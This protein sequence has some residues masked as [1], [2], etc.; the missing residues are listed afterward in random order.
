MKNIP[1]NEEQ[2][3]DELRFEAGIRIPKNKEAKKPVQKS[4]EKKP[5]QKIEQSIEKPSEDM[6][7]IEPKRIVDKIKIKTAF[8]SYSEEL[9]K[10]YARDAADRKI[11]QSYKETK[12]VGFWNKIGNGLKRVWTHGIFREY[13]R[14]KE[15]SKSQKDILE[16]RN[17]FVDE[18]LTNN[19]QNNLNAALIERL[20]S[21]DDLS[22]IAHKGEKVKKLEDQNIKSR[23]IDIIRRYTFDNMTDNEF[24]YYQ[25]QLINEIKQTN[26]DIFEDSF[27]D[28]NNLLETAKGLK[29]TYSHQQGL[30]NVDI[31]LDIILGNMKSGLRTEQKLNTVERLT[32]KLSKTKLGKFINETTL[33]S[34]LSIFQG[35]GNTV[36]TF[37]LYNKVAQIA[38]FGGTALLSGIL[39]SIRNRTYW[40]QKRSQHQREVAG[41]R[42][43]TID[44]KD[45]QRKALE[46]FRF[47]SINAATT[48]QEFDNIL[49]FIQDKE[50]VNKITYEDMSKYISE[51]SLVDSYI[52]LSDD[53]LIDLITYSS[54]NT[55]DSERTKLDIKRATLKVKLR[56]IC[57]DHNWTFSNETFDQY[58]ESNTKVNSLTL[59]KDENGIDQ[60]N[61]KFARFKSKAGLT[62]FALSTLTGL[63]I[64][65]GIQETSAFF[66]PNQQGA[67]EALFGHIDKN[68][69]SRTAL[70]SFTDF[71]QNKYSNYAG[72]YGGKV[73]N[74]SIEHKPAKISLEPGRELRLDSDGNYDLYTKGKLTSD[75]IISFKGRQLINNQEAWKKQGLL[76]DYKTNNVLSKDQIKSVISKE[77]FV[78]NNPDMVDVAGK[79]QWIRNKTTGVYD[80]NEQGINYGIDNNN[81]VIDISCMTSKGSFDAGKNVDI[82]EAIKNNNAKVL[83]SLSKDTS[84]KVFELPLTSD[85]LVIDNNS[86]IKSLFSINGNKVIFNGGQIEIAVKDSGT[87]NILATANGNNNV[88]NYIINS[89]NLETIKN[90]SIATIPDG[91]TKLPNMA[92]PPFIPILGGKP[93]SN[94]PKKTNDPMKE[95]PTSIEESFKEPTKE[96]VVITTEKKQAVSKVAIESK[97]EKKIIT[98][99]KASYKLAEIANQQNIDLTQYTRE[100]YAEFAIDNNLAINDE[101]LRMASWERMYTSVKDLREAIRNLKSKIE[102]SKEDLEFHKFSQEMKDKAKETDRF[103]EDKIS[104][105]SG[106]EKTNSWLYFQINKG[107]ET[108]KH[109][110]PKIFKTYITFKNL[111]DISPTLFLDMMRKLRDNNFDGDIKIFQDLCEHATVLNDQIVIHGND[112]YNVKKAANIIKNNFGPAIS[113][114]SFGYDDNNKSYSQILA[115]KI[116]KE[117]KMKNK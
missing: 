11:S 70:K 112:K 10:I 3:I 109:Y 9:A 94:L 82:I 79:R 32:E 13:Y 15:I 30:R 63:V 39:A 96:P 98:G 56:K 7:P 27:I 73:D 36:G 58:L 104:I 77:Q 107:I 67:V 44:E 26:K 115:E 31:D 2:E 75:N 60:Q 8:I 4:S 87:W 93:L 69:T 38:T 101:Q 100:E 55:I 37:L 48:I 5:V 86:P 90:I 57:E 35:L 14:Q 103:L 33:A 84:G 42:L 1:K 85:S 105:H 64:G 34:A 78:K 68:P 80:L 113:N 89:N 16:K 59:L 92:L 72:V 99:W 74:F 22:Q 91:V 24:I 76:I 88:G 116:K 81:P 23:I 50:K 17:L 111:K 12:P 18:D 114:I 46:R 47:Q 65:A 106:T 66:N 97:K 20:I 61:K 71:L 102:N 49:N 51:I 19:S 108:T 6:T 25:N 43:K 52:N 45:K 117:I 21:I 110:N 62:T 95:I 41:G 54:P 53:K 83:I 29:A 40:E 28:A